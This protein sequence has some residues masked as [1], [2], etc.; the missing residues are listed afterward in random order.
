MIIPYT[1]IIKEK[2][3]FV[4]LKY[5]AYKVSL[6]L[7]TSCEGAATWRISM[8]SKFGN[9]DHAKYN[10]NFQTVTP[11]ISRE[12]VIL[13]LCSTVAYWSTARTTLA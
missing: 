4:L 8:N 13:I 5:Y 11:G 1:I 10:T 2:K 12:I 7:K 3:C 9:S 6:L